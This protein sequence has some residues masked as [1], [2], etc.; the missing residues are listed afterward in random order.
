[1]PDAA[2]TSPGDPTE[3]A[4]EAWVARVLGVNL[5]EAALS[6]KAA[7][8]N[9]GP[10]PGV[11]PAKVLTS[12][13]LTSARAG[14]LPAEDGALPEQLTRLA[15]RYLAVLLDEPEMSTGTLTPGAAVG[16]ADQMLGVAD[17]L[18]AVGRLLKRWAAEIAAAKTAETAMRAA[19]A[20]PS[21]PEDFPELIA[22]YATHRQS[23]LDLQTQVAPLLR[24]LRAACEGLQESGTA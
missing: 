23:G 15:P 8:L 18:D 3:S 2:A 16:E 24:D 20:A 6:A 21:P 12:A 1:M 14:G 17:Q 19:Q 4:R 11:A 13:L 10:A 5:G 22:A 9:A 7:R